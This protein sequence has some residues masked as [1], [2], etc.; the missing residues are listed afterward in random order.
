MPASP[1]RWRIGRPRNARLLRGDRDD[2]GEDGR[3]RVAGRLV[4]RVV[5]LAAQPVVP[6]ARRVR[7]RGV[8]SLFGCGHG[9]IVS[10]VAANALVQGST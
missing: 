10:S 2:A 3:V 1:A 6:D 9:G 8:D 5:V 7:Y 4:D